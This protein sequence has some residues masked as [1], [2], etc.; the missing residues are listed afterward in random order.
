MFRMF[1]LKITRK[2]GRTYFRRN[3]SSTWT[4]TA[5]LNTPTALMTP[6][7]GSGPTMKPRS[8][9]SGITV[10]DVLNLFPGARVIAKDKPAF[11]PHCRK[12]SEGLRGNKV[13]LI[14]TDYDIGGNVRRRAVQKD[15]LETPKWRRDGKI[16]LRE[17][18]DGRIEWACLFCGRAVFT[19]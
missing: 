9:N 13:T 1:R 5:S 8:R 12:E 18:P 19:T 2:E 16:V 10:L 14:T 17:W 6:G 3:P 11:C 15:R 7:P 4:V